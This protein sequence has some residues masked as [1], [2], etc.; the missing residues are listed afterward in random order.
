MK[1]TKPTVRHYNHNTGKEISMEFFDKDVLH[2]SQ[3][4]D[5]ILPP[6]AGNGIRKRLLQIDYK[7]AGGL[8]MHVS[9]VTYQPR[10]MTDKTLLAEL[11]KYYKAQGHT[12]TCISEADENGLPCGIL[13]SV[14]DYWKELA[15]G[16]G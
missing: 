5:S 3:I 9:T 15:K 14:P 8:D 13:Y 7:N 16:R 11:C 4:M 2:G 12:V 6:F 1:S 10:S